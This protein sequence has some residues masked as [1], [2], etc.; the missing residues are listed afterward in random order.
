MPDNQG[1]NRRG[2]WQGFDFGGG[3][4]S[5]QSRNPWRFS[6]IYIIA[7]IAL[8]VVVRGFLGP[9]QQKSSS[10]NTFYS[11]L[12]AGDLQSVNIATDSVSWTT[13]EGQQYK[14]TLPSN[15]QTQDLV[16]QLAQANVRVTASQPSAWT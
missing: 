16:Q 7:A 11:Q 5:G 3:G 1:D 15:F 12:R 6:I 2:R 14:A 13:K 4:S 9:A 8:L 10:L